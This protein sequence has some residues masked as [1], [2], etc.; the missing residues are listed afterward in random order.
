[1]ILYILSAQDEVGMHL[2]ISEFKFCYTTVEHVSSITI[3]S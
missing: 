2:G 3:I 1:M